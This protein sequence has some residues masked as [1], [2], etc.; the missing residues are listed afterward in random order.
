MSASRRSGARSPAR[1]ARG[2]AVG[3]P[4]QQSGGDTGRVEDV[5][6][7]RDRVAGAHR[8]DR[9]GAAVITQPRQTDAEAVKRSPG[10]A[11]GVGVVDGLSAVPGAD[12]GEHVVDVG[13]DRGFADHEG[14]GDFSVRQARGD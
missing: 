12:L 7:V 14:G 5:Q 13:L 3:G 2:G 1:S 11:V 10:E 9:Q 8:L 6:G 4:E